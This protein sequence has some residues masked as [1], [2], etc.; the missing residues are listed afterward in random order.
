MAAGGAPRAVREVSSPRE[1]ASGSPAI[2]LLQTVVLDVPLA[3]RRSPVPEL[4]TR[5]PCRS[6]WL[7]RATPCAL[8]LSLNWAE[9]N[10]SY[11]E[12]ACRTSATC[13]IP[14]PARLH[15]LPEG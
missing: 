5:P 10:L 14:A 12:P 3:D 4:P 15:S 1:A 13:A 7:R 6:E 2:A 8:G 11:A 9:H